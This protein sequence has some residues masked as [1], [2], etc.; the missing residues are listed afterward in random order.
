M[1]S[2]IMLANSAIKRESAKCGKYQETECRGERGSAALFGGD[3]GKQASTL[4]SCRQRR[5]DN[6]AVTR[7]LP[8]P[9]SKIDGGERRQRA[10]FSRPIG[11]ARHRMGV[12]AASKAYISL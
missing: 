5:R 8:K 6:I 12:C 7:L 4:L 9:N 11:R 3:G 1:P 2:I 10:S